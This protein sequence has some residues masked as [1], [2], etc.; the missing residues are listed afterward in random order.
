MA[1]QIH[2]IKYHLSDL[3]LATFLSIFLLQMTSEFKDKKC[4]VNSNNS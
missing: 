1:I 3:S 2:D 4:H